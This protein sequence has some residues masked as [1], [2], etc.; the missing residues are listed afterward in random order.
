MRWSTRLATYSATDRASSGM[1]SNLSHWFLLASVAAGAAT[2][3]SVLAQEGASPLKRGE[4]LLATNCARCHATGAT[5]LSPHP[6][7]PPFRTLSRK[8]P[9]DGL[10]NP[11]Q[12]ACRLAIQTCLNSSSSL[13][14]WAR[15]SPI[16]NRSKCLEKTVSATAEK[17]LDVDHGYI[18]EVQALSPI[19]GDGS[20]RCRSQR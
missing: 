16:S 18:A 1:R 4:T 8:Y 14:M 20:R 7:A 19:G 5:G 11:W 12:K 15:S 17:A 3:S 13:R 10:A 6:A 9:I 2:I